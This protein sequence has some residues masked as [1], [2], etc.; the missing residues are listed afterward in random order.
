MRN[1]THRL[2]QEFE[3]AIHYPVIFTREVFALHNT[4]LRDLFQEAGKQCHRVLVVI[5]S[6][7]FDAYPGLPHDIAS[8]A[9]HYPDVMELVD[10]PF[11][12]RGG[13]VC[14][15]DPQE[16]DA[17]WALVERHRICRHSFVIAIGGGSVLDAAGYAVATVHRGI[18]LIRMPTTVLSQ[19]DGGVG[20][21]NGINYHGRKNFIG[22]FTPPSAV[23]NDSNFLSTLD[24]RDLRSGIA[25]AIKVALI[26]DSVFFDYLES[27][28][29]ELA[30]F[31]DDVMREMIGHCARLHLDH[32]REGGDPYEYGSARPL[33]FGHWSAHKLE[34][35]SDHAL[36]HGEAVA[37]G[38]AIDT[39]Y[40]FHAGMLPKAD[41]E[42]VVTLLQQVGF[43]LN[44]ATLDLLDVQLSLSEFQEHLGGVLTITLLS[45][46]GQGTDVHEIDESLMQRSIQQLM[47]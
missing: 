9:R 39:I 47:R 30:E 20:V 41:M 35:L 4:V 7:V 28:G 8:Y 12:V 15:T 46:I 38:I 13:E 25:E 21:K 33:D 24:A 45:A 11:I 16:V 31:N 22:T 5:D 43:D 40:S 1:L 29:R 42:R 44:D 37:I 18:R 3:L 26:R 14:K 27:H 17:I 19:C 2:E 34:E 23:I 32:I 10:R 36:R 6:G